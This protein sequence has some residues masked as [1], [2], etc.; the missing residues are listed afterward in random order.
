MK[1]SWKLN[2]LF[3]LIVFACLLSSFSIY[4]ADEYGGIYRNEEVIPT[5]NDPIYDNNYGTPSTEQLD[6]SSDG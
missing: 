5:D 6:N 1:R 4:A 2:V 3:V